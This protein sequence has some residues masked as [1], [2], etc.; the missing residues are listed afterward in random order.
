MKKWSRIVL[1][2]R[3][4]I[5]EWRSTAPW[6]TDAQLEENMHYKLQGQLFLA[7]MGLSLSRSAE[8]FAFGSAHSLIM[9]ELLS[10]VPRKAWKGEVDR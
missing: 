7:D 6:Q 4:F 1:I 5:F 3:D 2:P 10:E 8:E 9:N